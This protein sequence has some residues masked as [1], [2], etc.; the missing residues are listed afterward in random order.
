M[1]GMMMGAEDG[2]WWTAVL[3][4]PVQDRLGSA[5]IDDPAGGAGGDGIDV[6]VGEGGNEMGVHG[7][8]SC[9]VGGSRVA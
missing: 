1:V 5:G 6:I 9:A 4:D 2:R 7:L 3:L 8:N